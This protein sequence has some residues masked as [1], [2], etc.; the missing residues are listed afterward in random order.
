MKVEFER[1]EFACLQ[2][3]DMFVGECDCPDI[4]APHVQAISVRLV[5][6]ENMDLPKSK[7]APHYVYRITL[8]EKTP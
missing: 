3:G 1:I 2:V 6:G 7:S 8:K 5:M 4:F